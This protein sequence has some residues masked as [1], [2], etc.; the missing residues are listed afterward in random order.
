MGRRASHVT[1]E[2]ALDYV[3]GYGVHNDYSER[4]FQLEHGGQ[5]VKGKSADTFAPFGPYLATKD[6]LGDVHALDLWLCINGE[7]RQQ[8][9]TKNL[10]FG[11]PFLV[12]YLSRFMTLLPGDMISTGTPA[13]VGMGM[14]P[15]VFL[16]PGDVCTLGVAGLGEQQQTAVAYPGKA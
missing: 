12:S 13:G 16:R 3:A 6:E 15:P 2:H 14:K 4:E 10:I 11:V 8:G 5:W 1:E 9:N 7:R